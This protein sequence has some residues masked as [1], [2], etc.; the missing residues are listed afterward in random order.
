MRI[1]KYALIISVASI[2]LFASEINAGSS[3]SPVTTVSENHKKELT[4]DWG[5]M[6]GIAAIIT[7]LASLIPS[8]RA[9]K[10]MEDVNLYTAL[11]SSDAAN[12][13]KHGIFEHCVRQIL[14]EPDTRKRFLESLMMA[15]HE[16]SDQLAKLKAYLKDEDSFDQRIKG[17]KDEKIECLKDIKN[18]LAML[19]K[20]R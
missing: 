14:N 10:K 1:Y 17:S 15:L 5:Y 7:A 12:L 20:K 4:T 18:M 11:M 8:I 16:E 6:F 2:M 13:Y 3:P 9:I 19:F